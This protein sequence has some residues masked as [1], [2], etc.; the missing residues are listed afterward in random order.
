MSGQQ[1]PGARGVPQLVFVGLLLVLVGVGM[2]RMTALPGEQYW[3][4]VVAAGVAFW[5]LAVWWWR[6]GRTGSANAVR[7]WAHRSNR[8]HGVASRWQIFKTASAFAM[9]RRAKV[10][11]PSLREL[12]WWQRLRVP[13]TEYATPVARVSRQRIWS[14]CEDVTLRMGGPRMGKTGEL[15]CRILDAPGAVISTS[16]R[17]DLI[18]VTAQVRSR[19]GPIHVFNPAGAGQLASSIVFDP[20]TGCD[21]PTTAIH[22]AEDLLAGGSTGDGGSGE[23]EWWTQ[24][25][26]RALAALLHAAA[27]GERS[28]RDVLAWVA[29]PA[30][31][32]SEIV[33]L[34]RRSSA[35]SMETDAAQFLSTNERTQSSIT[36]TIMPAL[37]WLNDENAAA[38]AGVD[39]RPGTVAP[40][41]VEQLLDQ[42]ATVYMLGAEDANT[43]PLLTALTG[44]LAREARRIARN[45][46]SGRLDPPLTM[47]LD[48]AAIIAPIPLDKWTADMGGNN[49]TIHIAAQSRAQLRQRWADTGAAAILNNA[50]T[51]L[52]FGN[53]KDAADLND[54]CTLIGERDEEVATYGDGGKI[55]STTVRRVPVISPAQLSQLGKG[56]VVI[57]RQGM[58]PAVGKTPMA[59]K[60]RDVRKAARQERRAARIQS[61]QAAWA[62][63]SSTAARVAAIW[64]AEAYDRYPTLIARL[65][66]WWGPI[67][68]AFRGP[69]PDAFR[70]QFGT[71]FADTSW[72]D[73]VDGWTEPG[74]PGDG[75]EGGRP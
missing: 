31:H 50:G 11:R 59:W 61:L 45:Q 74:E 54:F 41:D 37:G 62:T 8:N 35:P 6:R 1:K 10:L 19:L 71:R 18:E 58:P 36:T 4:W 75:P 63:A 24:Q 52:L 16:T 39:A 51:V 21:K 27:L 55:V 60:R 22:R 28:M 26:C 69:D 13:V 67:R 5:T 53:T 20:L 12:T 44:H 70:A 29:D 7:R 3:P 43:A 42:R 23:R 47:A 48:E 30:E 46:P 40:F 38:A 32:A 56:Q 9:R 14:P 25:A 2:S 15:A 49:I 66:R 72:T 64:T 17:T 33:R 57:L 34:L 73:N 65:A 68:R